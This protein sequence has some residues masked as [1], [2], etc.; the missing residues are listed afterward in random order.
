MLNKLDTNNSG[1]EPILLPFDSVCANV[2]TIRLNDTAI[3]EYLEQAKE[4][5][6]NNNININSNINNNINS[7]DN[8]Y[9]IS[10]DIKVI[11]S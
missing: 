10:Y 9:S 4:N 7:R 5:A 11:K 6:K 1:K 8:K 2:A 3:I